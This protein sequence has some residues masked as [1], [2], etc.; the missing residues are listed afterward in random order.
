MNK[1]I[2]HIAA[3]L[4]L[5][6]GIMAANSCQNIM[7]D[8]VGASGFTITAAI[9]HR[10]GTK[11]D[12]GENAIH[13]LTQTWHIGDSVIGFGSDGKS[14][15]FSVTSVADN[16][17]ATL[18]LITAGDDAGT[19]MV[20]PAPGTVIYLFYAPGTT[21]DMMTSASSAT[22]NA[23]SISIASQTDAV[24][25]ILAASGKVASG[26]DLVMT[27][28]NCTAV[29]G[30]KNPTMAYA[31]TEYT[32]LSISGTGL[33]TS[34][35]FSVDEEGFLH[36]AYSTSGTL[37]RTFSKIT[38][39][40]N[41]FPGSP[42]FYFAACP[43]KTA[44]DL[45]VTASAGDKI[46]LSSKTIEAANYYY[47]DT[48]TF[49]ISNTEAG[50]PF[51]PLNESLDIPDL[52]D[53]SVPDY[54]IEDLETYHIPEG[55]L[56]GEISVAPGRRVL[57][58][59]GNLQ[60]QA[61]S[62][63]W[64]FAGSQLE[65]IGNAPG[66][67][68]ETGRETQSDWIDLFGWGATGHN[69][70]GQPPYSI[71]TSWGDYKTEEGTRD[72]ELLTREN[73]GDWGVCMGKEWRMLSSAEWR[74][75]GSRGKLQRA[76]IKLED[77]QTDVYGLVIVPDNY[78]PVFTN[79]DAFNPIY[80]WS[81]WLRAE[82]AGCVFLP[83]AGNRNGANVY[84]TGE[85]GIYWAPETYGQYD[86][87]SL[88]FDWMYLNVTSGGWRA[89][90]NSV[91]LVTDLTGGFVSVLDT[92]NGTV[93]ANKSSAK[94]G[95]VVTFT[96]LP[97]NGYEIG[98]I[99]VRDINGS[100]VEVFGT[101]GSYSFAQ[102]ESSSTISVSF[103]KHGPLTGYFSI[104]DGKRILFSRGNLYWDG[105]KWNL[106]AN[107]YDF[108]HYDGHAYDLACINGIRTKTPPGTV[109]SFFWS[110]NADYAR[111][112][113]YFDPE[114]A[115]NEVLFT[116][117]TD[118]CEK[119]NPSFSV[120][121]DTGFWRTLSEAE[122]WYLINTRGTGDTFFKCGVM[123]NS[124][125][126]LVIAPDGNEVPISA[127]YDAESWVAAEAAGFICIPMAG[128]RCD[129]TRHTTPRFSNPFDPD[130]ASYLASNSD[131]YSV[132]S[133]RMFQFTDNTINAFFGNNKW[134]A[135]PVRLVADCQ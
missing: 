131:S 14:Y 17:N 105:S 37:T 94:T 4:S 51:Y 2:Q 97:D 103:V 28:K 109:G 119:D 96:A 114:V 86:V 64:R 70:Y 91:R 69:S 80:A 102:P 15:A 52:A 100:P 121:G 68:T 99:L 124:E 108:R 18:S 38:E 59:K 39:S 24:P 63:K 42:V 48:P 33:N 117:K 35:D 127:S 10:G 82:A 25:A 118:D 75:I 26:Q 5:L 34:V 49:I 45:T 20:F 46:V 107:Q 71:S 55:A 50:L 78:T 3:L 106:E 54:N 6:T 31:D 61:S 73:G 56:S 129:R 41:S 60:Y 57:F 13:G 116:N 92:K 84:N 95:S 72:G 85:S 30:I 74:Y 32:G 44:A 77:G 111:M 130:Q 65:Y 40:D 87:F 12:Y 81:D 115:V 123:V 132:S 126:C 76:H 22:N 79:P 58:S 90:G 133:C 9:E 67:N 113:T 27:F 134:L 110:K 36:T 29:I 8:E 47:V 83:A 125:L 89:S 66:N 21:I 43:L 135:A 16:G 23:F 101:N 104:G 93:T 53:G 98:S 128:C 62:G 7:F 120:N 1:S 19:G 88:S 122:W 112:E 11:V